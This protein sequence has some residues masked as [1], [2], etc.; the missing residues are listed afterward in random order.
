MIRSRLIAA[1]VLLAALPMAPPA[2]AHPHVF[3][4]A[5]VDFVLDD[6][7]ELEALEITWRFDAFETLYTLSAEG[8]A[9]DAEGRLDE[10]ARRHLARQFG[11][12][13]DDF[14]GFERLKVAGETIALDRPS[15]LGVRLVDG[16]L[17]VRFTRRLP[18]PV[19]LDDGEAEVSV[20]EAT[21]YYAVSVAEAP[22][23]TGTEGCAA[24]VIP[25]EPDARLSAMQ[26]SLFDLGR[27]E[28]PAVAD[29][30]ALFADRVVLACD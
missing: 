17:E 21:Y 25:F 30:G 26:T 14:D 12:W 4:D 16:R 9:P 15:G 1:A 28:T 29:V 23:P 3:V 27:E 7:R 22:S 18:A 10:A 2:A 13:P 6:G 8:F 20:Y 24:R 11:D 5:G 19:A